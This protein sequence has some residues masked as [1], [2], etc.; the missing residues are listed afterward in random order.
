MAILSENVD[1]AMALWKTYAVRPFGDDALKSLTTDGEH[2]PG[3]V[4]R[5][6]HWIWQT[7]LWL[8]T[9]APGCLVI[10]Y[11]ASGVRQQ[12][13]V[14][15]GRLGRY[16]HAWRGADA[17][18]WGWIFVGVGFWALGY[19]CHLKT[20]LAAVK[21]L[22]WAIGIIAGAIGVLVLLRSLP[23]PSGL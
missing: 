18:G 22:G 8:L 11:G 10:V 12:R 15:F 7:V 13:L 23:V 19:F 16:E 4:L 6:F 1:A 5:V 17:V 3:P 20:G 14:T 2:N 9:I 21:F